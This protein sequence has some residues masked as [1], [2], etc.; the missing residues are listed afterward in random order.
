MKN[1]DIENIIA[2][3]ESCG[4]NLK[5]MVPVET[6]AKKY[7]VSVDKVNKELQKGIKVEYEHTNNKETAAIIASQHLEERLD[8]YEKLKEV[9]D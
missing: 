7:N 9:E 1:S 6:I 3:Y 8:Y 2:L 5:K 4:C